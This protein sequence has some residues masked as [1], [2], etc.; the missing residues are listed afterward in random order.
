MNPL[1]RICLNCGKLFEIKDSRQK[2]CNDKC[3][4]KYRNN[5]EKLAQQRAFQ[6]MRL[7]LG[8]T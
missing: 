4:K 3:G 5:Q 7:I 1:L 6:R 2:F 8:K